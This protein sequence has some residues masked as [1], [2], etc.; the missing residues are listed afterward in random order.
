MIQPIEAV[1]LKGQAVFLEPLKKEDAEELALAVQDGELYDLFTTFVPKPEKAKDYI[2][3]ALKQRDETGS[4]P[5]A[6][7]DVKTK[8]FIG[9]TRFFNWVANDFR[10]EIGHTWLKKSYQKGIANT[11]AKFLLLSHAF[12]QLKMI[13]VEFR[14]DFL[15][16]P[17]RQAIEKLGAKWVGV[18]LRH[19]VM[20]NGRVRDT[21][22]YCIL[23]HEW[24]GVKQNLNFRLQNLRIRA[25][26]E[27]KK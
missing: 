13:G 5:F 24:P 23:D 7:R 14:T 26:D 17:S 18:F 11:E 3:E 15:N 19:R 6:I 9:S 4:L 8:K 2:Q 20:P 10:V 16:F 27:T 25:K 12:E 21:V 22:V 1:K